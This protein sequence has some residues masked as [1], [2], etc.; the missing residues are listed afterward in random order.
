MSLGAEV[1]SVAFAP[2]AKPAKDRFVIARFAVVVHPQRM[3]KML[4]ATKAPLGLS[5]T[6]VFRSVRSPMNV[7]GRLHCGHILTG[8]A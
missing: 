4:T 5:L 1:G 6:G 7:Q 8:A 2:R 3:L